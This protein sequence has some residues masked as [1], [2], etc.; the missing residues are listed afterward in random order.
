MS[1]HAINTNVT[2][3]VA[4]DG[5]DFLSGEVEKQ[6]HAAFF[7]HSSSCVGEGTSWRSVRARRGNK[8]LLNMAQISGLEQ[9][10]STFFNKSLHLSHNLYIS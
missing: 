2:S 1:L 6:Q 5:I 9:N 4:H 10:R 7:S 8:T 3:G